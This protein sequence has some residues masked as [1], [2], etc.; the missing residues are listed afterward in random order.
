M[1]DKRLC[2]C[3]KKAMGSPSKIAASLEED[4]AKFEQ[5]ES[6]SLLK[7]HLTRE[8][9]DAIKQKQTSYG[10]GLKDAIQSGLKHPDSGV[11]VYAPD[12]EAYSVFAQ[13]FDLII[14]DYHGGFGPSDVHPAMDFGDPST[15]GN[16][17][18]E[19][20]FVI[21]TRVRCGRSLEGY[22]FNPTMT[23]AHYI[24]IQ[25]KV[26]VPEEEPVPTVL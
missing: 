13:L 23:K 12:P 21:S 1:C 24:E 11:G 8:I 14:Q 4:F 22:P 25:D 26:R 6:K 10:S 18:P 3:A 20:K 17:D 5:M 7:K 9:F 19:A 15:L 16:L 2:N